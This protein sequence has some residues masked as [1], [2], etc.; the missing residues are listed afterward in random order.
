MGKAAASRNPTS[1]RETT[2]MARSVRH[3]NEKDGRRGPRGEHHLDGEVTVV[4]WGER[5][6]IKE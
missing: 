3:P 2:V 1:D 5:S 4:A 6:P